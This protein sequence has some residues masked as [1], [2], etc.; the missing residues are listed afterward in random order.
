[1]VRAFIDRER[2]R[3]LTG[4]QRTNSIKGKRRIGAG[5]FNFPGGSQEAYCRAIEKETVPAAKWVLETIL[6]NAETAAKNRSPLCDDTG[7]PHLFL[8]VGPKRSVTG[9]LLESIHEGV[10]QGLR[11]LPG[12]PMAIKGNDMQRLDQ[13]GGLDEDPGALA[14][15][16]KLIKPVEED[17]L[18]L[19]VLMFGGGPAIR[20][21][22][23][24]VFHKHSVKVV[25]DEIISRA[26][27]AVALLDVR[28]VPCRNRQVTVRGSVAGR[29]T[30]YDHNT[31]RNWAMHYRW[32]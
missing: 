22:T 17:V 32:R 24:R 29:G 9:E 8:E 19:H 18:R 23:H 25:T 15:S 21:I 14:P 7:I 12:R 28:R 1:M 20:G 4:R 2:L 5:G 30:V 27:E 6:E 13:S 3:I 16:P 11:E 31:Q 26:S 10:K